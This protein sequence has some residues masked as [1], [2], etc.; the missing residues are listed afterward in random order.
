MLRR[1]VIRRGK[2]SANDLVARRSCISRCGPGLCCSRVPGI[3][4]GRSERAGV[5]HLV[6]SIIKRI[7]R[8]RFDFSNK[9]LLRS[10]PTISIRIVDRIDRINTVLRPAT[11]NHHHR[12]KPDKP[13]AIRHEIITHTG[14]PR[15]QRPLSCTPHE[16]ASYSLIESYKIRYFLVK[17]HHRPVDHGGWRSPQSEHSRGGVSTALSGHALSARS[18]QAIPMQ[19]HGHA[20]H[21]TPV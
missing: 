11:N 19:G 12:C 5:Q 14:L 9:M 20:T 1:V 4:G 6:D 16:E 7:P 17:S 21:H 15:F 10:C 13:H 3:R 8:I 18:P 2:Q